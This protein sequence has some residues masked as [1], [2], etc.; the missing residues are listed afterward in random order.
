MLLFLNLSKGAVCDTR[1]RTDSIQ[2]RTQSTSQLRETFP[3]DVGWFQQTL[4]LFP[5]T[6]WTSGCQIWKQRETKTALCASVS[7]QRKKNPIVWW[8]TS[9]PWM[10]SEDVEDFEIIRVG[11]I[12]HKEWCEVCRWIGI[13]SQNQSCQVPLQNKSVVGRKSGR[14]FMDTQNSDIDDKSGLKK[15]H[16]SSKG[17]YH[18]LCCLKF[19]SGTGSS[20]QNVFQ[21]KRKRTSWIFSC[22]TQAIDILPVQY[23]L[24]CS[25]C[26]FLHPDKTYVLHFFARHQPIWASRFPSQTIQT[27]KYSATKKIQIQRSVRKGKV[28]NWH[29][30]MSISHLLFKHKTKA[31]V[32]VTSVHHLR[33]FHLFISRWS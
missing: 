7:V 24:H 3:R 2:T 8:E 4:N 27:E 18:Q 14:T 23:A 31:K 5:S 10:R 33:N 32:K 28:V 29:I 6:L 11:S 15:S 25:T 30:S 16:P 20:T 26:C 22:K 21:H 12:G 19:S 1:I 17:A 9:W 13:S